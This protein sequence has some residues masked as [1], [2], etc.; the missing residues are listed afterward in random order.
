MFWFFKNKHLH[1]RIKEIEKSLG[2]SFSKIKNEF[3]VVHKR[4]HESHTITNKKLDE[5]HYRLS[6]LENLFSSVL[7]QKY[8]PEKSKKVVDGLLEDEKP[9]HFS[10]LTDGQKRLFAEIIGLHIETGSEWIALVEVAKQAPP[11]KEYKRVRSTLSEFTSVLEEAGLLNKKIQRKKAFV[12]VTNKGILYV[13]E[14]RAKRLRKVM[15]I[16]S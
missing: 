16:T 1:N 7:S 15:K 2:I 8:I 3:L 10:T 4:V 5:L 6:S 12:K 9:L 11:G 13:D 14:D